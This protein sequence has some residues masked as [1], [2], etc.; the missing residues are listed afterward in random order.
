MTIHQHS[1]NSLPTSLLTIIVVLFACLL[2]LWLEHADAAQ[3][4]VT[5][6]QELLSAARS[7]EAA[8]EYEQAVPAYRVYLTARPE[9]DTVREV[10]ARVLSWQGNY[11][12]A[13]ALYEDI[14]TR[15]PV[16]LEVR[17]ALA[18]VKSWQ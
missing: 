4:S 7:F 5:S 10:L 15:H 11:D 9:D 12:E 8:R 16:D 13:V 2:G 6:P 3:P 14:L 17:V 18:R 1:R